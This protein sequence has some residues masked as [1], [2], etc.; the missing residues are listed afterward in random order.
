MW[1][2]AAAALIALLIGLALVGLWA[3]AQSRER[4]AR[5]RQA[6]EQRWAA[7]GITRYRMGIVDNGCRYV[8]HVREASSELVGLQQ[9]CRFQPSSVISLF[10]LL[11][12]DGVVERLCD[13]RGC[14]CES[15]TSA[16]ATYH[17]ELGYPKSL[18]IDVELRPAW[19]SADVWRHILADGRLPPCTTHQI[20]TIEVAELAEE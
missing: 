5:E 16:W 11:D 8:A 6:A 14:P 15:A 20:T 7:A 9:A 19:L 4:Q 17:P 2:L 18:V 12:Q 13:T 1:R 3:G 10:E